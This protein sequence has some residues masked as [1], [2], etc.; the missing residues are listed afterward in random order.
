MDEQFTPYEIDNDTFKKM[1]AK[2]LGML[3]YFKAFCQEHNLMFYLCGGGEIGAETALKLIDNETVDYQSSIAD[4]AVYSRFD[5]S[6]C[7]VEGKSGVK[8][9]IFD[10]DDTLYSEKEYVKSGY[11]QVSD[12]LGGGFEDKLWFF[13]ENGR[14]AIDDLLKE[15][16]RECER[17]TVLNIYRSH[18]PSINLYDGIA[19]IIEELKRQGIKV[20]IITDGRPIGQR[21][22]LEA[23][24]LFDIVDDVI[25]T[26]ELGGEQFKKPCDIAFRIMMTKWRLDPSEV[27]YVG[28]NVNKDFQAPRQLGMKTI[29][30]RNKDG[31]YD[32]NDAN[33]IYSVCNL[34][35]ILYAI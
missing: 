27:I 12:C 26:D 9:V 16:N 6:V 21:N 5:Q 10:L 4:G 31:L 13:F 11:K 28:D 15:I 8:G 30:L 34:E 18:K 20:G 1:Q 17:E 24:G 33:G 32:R 25:I 23:L 14:P 3:L 2:M 22:K 35:E 7:I 19:S 29:W